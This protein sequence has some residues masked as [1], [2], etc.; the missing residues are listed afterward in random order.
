METNRGLEL[1]DTRT[2]KHK[3]LNHWLMLDLVERRIYFRTQRLYEERV[4]VEGRA[5][6]DWL[7]AESEALRTLYAASQPRRAAWSPP[8]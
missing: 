2:T 3:G 4:H 6:E 8:M 7:K 1:R 5:L